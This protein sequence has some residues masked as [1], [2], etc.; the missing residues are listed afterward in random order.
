MLTD[1]AAHRLT[2][3]TFKDI[4]RSLY[5]IA[6]KVRDRCDVTSTFSAILLLGT[7]ILKDGS[8]EKKFFFFQSPM[9]GLDDHCLYN[10]SA[11][12]DTLT[13]SF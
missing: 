3:N 12:G 13:S 5:Q 2:R 9:V 1:G 6:E 7:T 8:S 11:M 10:Q 4:C